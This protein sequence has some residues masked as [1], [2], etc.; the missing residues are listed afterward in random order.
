MAGLT[1]LVEIWIAPFFR[2]EISPCLPSV[3]E[4]SAS[5][6]GSDENIISQGFRH[7]RVSAGSAPT[8]PSLLDLF[9]SNTRVR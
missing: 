9:Q 7:S 5:S 2:K 6:F 1:V 4:D 3:R 8:M